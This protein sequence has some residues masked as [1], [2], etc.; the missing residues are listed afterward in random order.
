MLL[1]SVLLLGK[2]MHHI[3]NSDHFSK[4]I[5]LIIFSSFWLLSCSN[6]SFNTN[7]D[8]NPIEQYFAVSDVVI[9]EEADLAQ[10]NTQYITA[11][12]GESCQQSSN[13]AP[14]N[15]RDARTHA[16]Q[17]ATK[18]NANAIV[19]SPCIS[20]DNPEAGCITARICSGKVFKVTPISNETER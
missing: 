17:Q 3:K 16:R 5:G 1:Y 8:A 11:I 13:Q 9:Y 7:L 12:E 19:F 18:H 4:K 2:T 10:L 6:Y 20:L 14:A 15:D